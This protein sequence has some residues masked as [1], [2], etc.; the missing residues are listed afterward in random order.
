[1]RRLSVPSLL[2]LD[3]KLLP[4]TNIVACVKEATHQEGAFYYEE[5]Q[6]QEVDV[7]LLEWVRLPCFFWALAMLP[8]SAEFLE[9]WC[10]KLRAMIAIRERLQYTGVRKRKVRQHFIVP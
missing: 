1:M 10:A 6:E 3:I 4:K 2:H 8:K 9:V 5:C 7:D